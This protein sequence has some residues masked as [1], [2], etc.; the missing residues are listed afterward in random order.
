MMACGHSGEIFGQGLAI[1][2]MFDC[3]QFLLSRLQHW[4]QGLKLESGMFN[5]TDLTEFEAHIV[6]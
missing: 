1:L 4:D 3:F 2:N 6:P 5:H